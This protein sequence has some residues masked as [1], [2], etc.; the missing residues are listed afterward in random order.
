MKNNWSERSSIIANILNP[1]FCGKVLRTTLKSYKDETSIGM[2]Y[3]MIY[4]ILP[5]ILHKNTREL[6]PSTTRIKFY[7]WLKEN[8]NIRI[9]LAERIK[10]MV[11]Y[12]QESL[13]FLIYHEAI[14]IDDSGLTSV[15]K[16]KKDNST[17]N[18]TKEL[19]DIFHKSRFFGK[20][21][22]K[23]GNIETIFAVL[24]IKP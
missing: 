13:Q 12:T 11:M 7:D 22:S 20:W 21:L 5:I 2:S 23:I 9:G 6:L 17:L 8:P 1:A 19:V 24:G 18:E 4:L 16:Y 10:N 15:I 14:Q 3:S